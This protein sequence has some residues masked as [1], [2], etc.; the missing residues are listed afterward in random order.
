ML[1]ITYGKIEDF[2][3]NFLILY[4]Y[5]GLRLKPSATKIIEGLNTI[6]FGQRAIE[7]VLGHFRS[8]EDKEKKIA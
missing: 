4:A 5:I 2:F 6:K 7:T 3:F 8:E 1:S